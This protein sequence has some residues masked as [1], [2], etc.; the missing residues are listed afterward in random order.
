MSISRG[1]GNDS[2]KVEDASKTCNGIPI[3]SDVNLE[4]EEGEHV[5]LIGPNGSGKTTLLSCL[6]GHDHFDHGNIYSKYSRDEWGYLEQND[7]V[8]G[9]ES[10][11]GYLM[12]SNQ[13]NY[14]IW[15]KYIL[16][17]C[18]PMS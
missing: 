12:K 9:D 1:I 6:I 14:E 17:T 11:I 10:L 15:K 13:V 2:L 7:Y 3:F 5:Y 16:V 4:I 18:N 8:H